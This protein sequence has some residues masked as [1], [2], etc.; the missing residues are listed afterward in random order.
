MPGVLR[1]PH[2]REIVALA[3]PALG[4]LAAEPLYLLVDTA[5][6]GHLG[7]RELA[8]LALAASVL[9]VVTALCNFLAYGTTAQVARLSGAGEG[10]RAREIAAQAF[11]LSLGLGVLV[12]LAVIALADPLVA[13]LGGEGETADLAARYL[14]LSAIGLPAALLALGGQGFLRGV[15]DL[16]TPLVI[17]GVANLVNAILEVV[18]VYGFDTG[19]D[20]SALGT[21]VAQAGMGVAFAVLLLRGGGPGVSRRPR[22]DLLRPLL[23]MGGDIV[24]RT[25]A[26]LGAFVLASAVVARAGEP[27]LAA[28]QI[29]FQLFVFLALTLDALAIAGQVLV[30]RRLGARDA[31]GAAAVG[32]RLVVLSAALGVAVALL[33]L[34]GRSLIPQ[35]FTGDDA[36]LERAAALWPLFALLLPLGAVTFAFD[37]ILIGAGDTRFLAGAMVLALLAFAPVALLALHRGWGVVGVWAGLNW[38]IVVRAAST[39]WR[40]RSGRWAVVGAR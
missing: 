4:A 10:D 14:R 38:L 22:P 11:W 7:T 15:A 16:R 20:G 27:S 17:L 3:L 40:F 28:H 36:V 30:G 6:V 21:V 8:A 18:L 33:L 34:A 29:A 24:V 9:G 1:S 25:A 26:L 2:D 19:L 39:G 37:G 23:R 13:L 31:A 35:A 5:I 12:A 32:R